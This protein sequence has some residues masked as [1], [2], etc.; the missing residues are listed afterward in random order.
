MLLYIQEKL[1]DIWK[2]NVLED[3]ESGNLEYMTVEEFLIDL[4]NKFGGR[5]NE[6]VNVVKLKKVEQEIIEEFVQEFRR[7][8]R[9]SKYEGR[10]LI[11]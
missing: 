9:G 3:L 10:L 1:V 5:D 4:K 2:K 6:I 11:K 7:A 8:V